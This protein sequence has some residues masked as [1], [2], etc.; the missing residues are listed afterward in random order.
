VDFIA[1]GDWF[2]G[3]VADIAI[4]GAVGL[5]LL[6]SLLG[7]RPWGREEAPG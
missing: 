6:I 4:V 5:I 7:V 1:Y 3:N 2:I